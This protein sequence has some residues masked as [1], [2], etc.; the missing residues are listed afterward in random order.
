[1]RGGQTFHFVYALRLILIIFPPDKSSE[2]DDSFQDRQRTGGGLSMHSFRRNEHGASP[3]TR[4]D[5]SMFSRGTH[6]KWETRSSGRSDRD[7]DSRSEWDSGV[8]Y[9]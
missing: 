6:G 5:T 8:V 3:P 4:G 7:S 9:T 2:F 1:M